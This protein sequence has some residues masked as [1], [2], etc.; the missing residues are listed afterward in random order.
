MAQQRTEAH[1]GRE[2]E[3]CAGVAQRHRASAF[4]AGLRGF[5][6]RLPPQ[7]LRYN[8]RMEKAPETKGIVRLLVEEKSGAWWVD[9]GLMFRPVAD[10][11]RRGWNKIGFRTLM[12]KRTDPLQPTGQKIFPRLRIVPRPVVKHTPG[13]YFD[14]AGWGNVRGF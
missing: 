1:V 7:T 3:K 11:H 13:G 12:I 4:Q 5:E 14:I 6:S 9:Q 10:E 2:E 8:R